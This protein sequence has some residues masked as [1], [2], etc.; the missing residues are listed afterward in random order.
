VTLQSPEYYADAAA[1]AKPRSVRKIQF[2]ILARDARTQQLADGTVEQR[3]KKLTHDAEARIR[4]LALLYQDP[5]TRKLVADHLGDL[6]TTSRVLHE[7]TW[8]IRN[9]HE[10][11]MSK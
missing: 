5:S 7:L 1:L 4:E 6:W 3:I 9:P 10:Q 2:E 8:A 11:D